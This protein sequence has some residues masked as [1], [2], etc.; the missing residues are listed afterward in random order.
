MLEAAEG[1]YDEILCC[2]D[3]V[4]YGACPN[5]TVEW[6]IQHV[7]TLVRGNHD[8]VSVGLDD[9]EGY[10]AVATT[11][12]YWTSTVLTEPN[13]VFLRQMPRG[14]VQHSKTWLMHGSPIDEDLYLIQECDARGMEQFLPGPVNFFGHTHRQGGF[15][16]VKN[17]LRPIEQVPEL[18]TSSVLKLDPSAHYLIN[19]GSVGQPRDTDWRAAYC[20]YDDAEASVRFF[21]VKYDVEAAAKTILAAGLPELLAKRLFLGK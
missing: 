18:E 14:P 10:N 9:T 3:L 21:R 5:E 13:K 20:I 2:G 19:P 15:A 12:L 17:C 8:K 16:Y 7:K 1:H 11:S 6:C 4:G